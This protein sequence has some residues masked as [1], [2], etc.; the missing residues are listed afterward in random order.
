MNKKP[1]KINEGINMEDIITINDEIYVKKDSTNI[2]NK[3]D[4][5]TYC[6]IRSYAS[7][8]FCGYVL[9]K[10]SRPNGINIILSNARRIWKWEGAC[11]LSQLAVDGSKKIDN[12]KIA[13]EVPIIYIA[14]VIEI[15][16]MSKDAKKMIMKA[17]VWKF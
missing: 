8:V 16:P 13:I 14:N 7:G 3:F 12:C 9:E 5:T 10:H 6:I 1:K 2:N 15:I 4:N 11:S 17:K